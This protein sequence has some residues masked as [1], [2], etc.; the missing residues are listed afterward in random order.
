MICTF[1]RKMAIIK[2]K[3]K[4]TSMICMKTVERT[5]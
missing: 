4:E 1:M 3:I 2:L 5:L